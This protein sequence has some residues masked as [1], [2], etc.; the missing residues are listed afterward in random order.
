MAWS[1]R[2]VLHDP[3]HAVVLVQ[4]NAFTYRLGEVP[5]LPANAPPDRR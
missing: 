5:L 2:R 1:R 3:I 4:S